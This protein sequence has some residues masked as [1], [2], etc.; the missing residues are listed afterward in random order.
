MTAEPNDDIA[1]LLGALPP[2]PS[3]WV[4]T[5]AELPRLQEAV[6]WAGSH[7]TGDLAEAL[8]H[9]GLDPNERRVRAAE[10]LRGIP[11]AQAGAVEERVVGRGGQRSAR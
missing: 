8:R 2:A 11:R 7:G 1:E 10:R 4:M 5:A 9:F 6:H 3:D